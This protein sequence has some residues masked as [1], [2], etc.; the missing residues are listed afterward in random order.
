MLIYIH[1]YPFNMQHNIQLCN[2]CDLFGFN[3][4]MLHIYGRAF[5]FHRKVGFKCV[6]VEGDGAC[7]NTCLQKP[8]QQVKY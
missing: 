6:G 3:K 2:L 8:A 4:Q 5:M 7:E 1:M